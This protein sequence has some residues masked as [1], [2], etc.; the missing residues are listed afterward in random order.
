[1][2]RLGFVSAA[3]LIAAAASILPPPTPDEAIARQRAEVQEAVRTSPCRRGASPDEIVVC[4]RL[5]RAAPGVPVSGYRPSD[6][7]AAP[8]RG[9]WFELVRG[10][11]SISCCAIE[12]SHGT[13]AGLS[14]RIRF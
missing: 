9:P 13:G 14:L 8:E 4:G 7:W 6:E 2:P 5:T 11:L 1:M 10:P 3:L 12:G